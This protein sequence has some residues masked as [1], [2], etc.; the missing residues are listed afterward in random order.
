M[1]GIFTDPQ[2]DEN[3]SNFSAYYI[4]G[5]GKKVNSHLFLIPHYDNSGINGEKIET[6]CPP[7]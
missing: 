1:A 2:F 6:L 7:I 3:S 4:K 5:G